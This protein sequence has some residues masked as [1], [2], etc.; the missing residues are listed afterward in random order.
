MKTDKSITVRRG[1]HNGV[2]NVQACKIIIIP[3]EKKNTVVASKQKNL[4]TSTIR[5][6]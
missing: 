4:A 2:L 5:I 3:A 6:N 1:V